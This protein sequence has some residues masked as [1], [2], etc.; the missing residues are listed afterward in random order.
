VTETWEMNDLSV[1]EGFEHVC[2]WVIDDQP[3][4]LKTRTRPIV[5]LPARRFEAEPPFASSRGRGAYQYGL[6]PQTVIR[7]P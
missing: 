5:N 1:E 2:Y 7:W 4:R 6:S 3:A